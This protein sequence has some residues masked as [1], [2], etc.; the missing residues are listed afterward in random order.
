MRP[1][2]SD[3]AAEP[4]PAHNESVLVANT[5][6]PLHYTITKSPCENTFLEGLVA[7]ISLST[8]FGYV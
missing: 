4:Q 1:A 8:L 5:P 3:K 2:N 6:D 7:L